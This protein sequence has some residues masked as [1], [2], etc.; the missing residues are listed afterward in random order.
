[1]KTKSLLMVVLAIALLSAIAFAAANL[2]RTP[3]SN[4]AQ[5][6]AKMT[7]KMPEK[8]SL[9]LVPYSLNRL[10]LPR[11]TGSAALRY[12]PAKSSTLISG[13]VSGLSPNTTYTVYLYAPKLGFHHGL[14]F[15]TTANGVGIF[16]D[17]VKGDHSH[18]LPMVINDDSKKVTILYGR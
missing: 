8:V 3:M 4:S 12:D 11:A 9:T 2:P 7:G 17:W 14:N 16:N 1:M 13:R 10:L 18:H 5:T 15:K 6:P